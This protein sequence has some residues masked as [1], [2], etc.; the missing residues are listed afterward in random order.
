V[1]Q[2]KI[3]SSSDKIRGW[4]SKV[5]DRCRPEFLD[6]N[7]LTVNSARFLIGRANSTGTATPQLARKSNTALSNRRTSF[8]HCASRDAETAFMA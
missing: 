2:Q 6:M 8:P 1:T 5:Q 4:V 7:R 3:A